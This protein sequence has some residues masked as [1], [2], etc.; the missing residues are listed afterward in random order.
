MVYGNVFSKKQ[1]KLI[2]T[3]ADSKKGII[4]FPLQIGKVYNIKDNNFSTKKKIQKTPH[5]TES[6]YRKEKIK[7]PLPIQNNNLSTVTEI[8]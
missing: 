2:W 6:F 3:Y 5:N 4:N 1:K 8:Q 7:K